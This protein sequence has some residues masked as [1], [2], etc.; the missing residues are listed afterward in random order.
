MAIHVCV[1]EGESKWWVDLGGSG[2]G[3][4]SS[5]LEEAVGIGAPLEEVGRA[6]HTGDGQSRPDHTTDAFPCA[7]R[8]EM[9][10]SKQA[11]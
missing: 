5:G 8:V 2:G 3:G 10:P 4:D 6:G 9:V 7:S 1:K 11:C